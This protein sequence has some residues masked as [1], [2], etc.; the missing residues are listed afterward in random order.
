MKSVLLSALCCA[1]TIQAANADEVRL[2]D[3]RVYFGTVAERGA[4]LM[5]TTRD[6][7]VRVP[8]ADVLGTRDAATLE[9]ELG[10]LSA[11]VATGAFASG[12]RM[13]MNT[14]TRR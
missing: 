11:R 3:G 14:M 4:E 10:D 9:K 2:R 6:G 13:Y 8:K 5:I 1:L 12:S 7:I